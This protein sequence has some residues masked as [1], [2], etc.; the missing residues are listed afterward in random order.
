MYVACG[1][2]SR[3]YYGWADEYDAKVVVVSQEVVNIMTDE[4]TRLIET[5]RWVGLPARLDAIMAPPLS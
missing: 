2:F 3:L 4:G 5:R 1:T